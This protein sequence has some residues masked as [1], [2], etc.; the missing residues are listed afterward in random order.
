MIGLLGDR[1]MKHLTDYQCKKNT[2]KVAG[3]LGCKVRDL[4]LRVN[5]DANYLG[6][7]GRDLFL[8]SVS[9]LK[10]RKLDLVSDGHICTSL[11]LFHDSITKI[12]CVYLSA[13]SQNGISNWF[14]GAFWW[15]RKDLASHYS[16]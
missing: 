10:F 13:F 8:A 3:A 11:S 14:H 2:V 4:N 1:E 16:C 15:R 6:M 9:Q 12:T 5:S 7:S